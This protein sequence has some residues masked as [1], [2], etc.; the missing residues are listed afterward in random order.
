MGKVLIASIGAG[1]PKSSESSTSYEKTNYRFE[2]SEIEK[3]ASFIMEPIIEQSTPDYVLL[4]GTKASCWKDLFLNYVLEIKDKDETITDKKITSYLDVLEKVKKDYSYNASYEELDKVDFSLLCHVL[5]LRFGCQFKILLLKYGLNKGE[6]WGNFERMSQIKEWMASEKSLEVSLD[7]THSF[8]SLPFYQY[9]CI[10]YLAEISDSKIVLENIYYGMF[11]AKRD[12]Q[13]T[14]IINLNETMKLLKLVNGI[15]ALHAYGNVKT[16]SDSM[17]GNVEIQKLLRVFEY[18]I[19]TNDFHKIAYSVEKL[20]KN[21]NITNVAP[22]ESELLIHLQNKMKRFKLRSNLKETKLQFEMAKWYWEQCR[23]GQTI[24]ILQET[25]RTFLV[26]ILKED[27]TSKF[28]KWK[29]DDEENR[30]NS[31]NELSYVVKSKENKNNS[32]KVVAEKKYNYEW[33]YDKYCKFGKPFRNKVAHNL[34]KTN[35]LETDLN[36]TETITELQKN[37]EDLH[38]YIIGLGVILEDYNWQEK[39]RRDVCAFHNENHPRESDKIQLIVIIGKQR[40]DNLPSIQKKYSNA[41]IKYVN[42]YTDRGKSE[43]ERK[44]FV[45]NIINSISSYVNEAD[46][47]QTIIAIK[48]EN[49]ITDVKLYKRLKQDRYNVKILELDING[50]YDLMNLEE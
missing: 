27:K 23:Y 15:H 1:S 13:Y 17:E 46:K 16:I 21:L 50:K 11:E 39:F 25:V 3:K 40:K 37:I 42:R 9:M 32:G 45:R 35:D 48:P 18:A 12:L 43:K 8:R 6:N 47:K 22:Y 14:P 36:V 33:L 41:T 10:N 26:S 5:K 29:L 44:S 31:I 49:M 4:L 7:I 24:T 19:S 30:K 2:E 38:E 34:F 20:Q 28:V